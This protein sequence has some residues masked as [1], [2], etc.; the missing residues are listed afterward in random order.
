MITLQASSFTCQDPVQI[1]LHSGTNTTQLQRMSVSQR[2][3]VPIPISSTWSVE[4]HITNISWFLGR[5]KMERKGKNLYTSTIFS[6]V[7]QWDG[8]THSNALPH[9]WPNETYRLN[10]VATASMATSTIA[11]E[12]CT[13][14]SGQSLLCSH[15]FYCRIPN[16]LMSKSVL[17]GY[18]FFSINKW[19][20]VS[21]EN[22]E[23]STWRVMLLQ[24]V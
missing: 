18:Q 3:L 13:N 8:G 1:M 16:T 15:S 11:L 10:D 6:S 21:K 24:I 9:A 19:I 14:F 23:F 12:N 2:I 17:Q 5:I 20:R 4:T 22:L 7:S